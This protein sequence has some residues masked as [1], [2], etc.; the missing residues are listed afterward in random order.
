MFGRLS[1]SLSS[2]IRWTGEHIKY[3]TTILVVL[4]FCDAISRYLFA[5]SKAWVTDLEWHVFAMIFLLGAA[6]ALQ[7]DQHVRVDV[8]YAKWSERRKAWLNL[9]GTL[10]FLIPW[11][12]IV[13]YTGFHYTENSFAI[14]E[15]SPDPGGLPV[16]WLIKGA[17]PVGF[18]L[19]LIQALSSC[20]EQIRIINREPA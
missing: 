12:A 5:T 14:G 20:I 10:F 16:R 15:G 18:I 4:I 6:Y 3:L 17:I 11:C 9:M 13:I 1:L 8:F 2:F 19:L 7:E